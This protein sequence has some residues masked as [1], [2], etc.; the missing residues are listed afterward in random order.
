MKKISLAL[1]TVWCMI[2]LSSCRRVVGEGPTIT[3]KRS[4]SDFTGVEMDVP[5][6]LYY[7]PGNLFSVEIVAQQNILDLIETNVTADDILRVKVRNSVNIKSHEPV[8]VKV[9]APNLKWLGVNGSGNVNVLESFQ[10][11]SLTLSVNGSGDMT[12]ARLNTEDLQARIS[13]SGNIRV[14]AGSGTRETLSIS[15][16]GDIDAAGYVVADATTSSSGSGSMR[17][18]VTSNLECKISGSGSV[19]YKGTPKVTTKI[20]GSGRVEPL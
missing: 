15:G 12:L 13:G 16:S 9:T 5:G 18:N 7:T 1:L 17:V 20:S 8:I 4:T 19:M 14:H 6:D 3:Q 11:A 2:V 10:P